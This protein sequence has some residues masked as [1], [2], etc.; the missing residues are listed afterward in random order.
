[1]SGDY[2]FTHDYTGFATTDNWRHI[3]VFKRRNWLPDKEIA[4]LNMIAYSGSDSNNVEIVYQQDRLKLLIDQTIE[5]DTLI[6]EGRSL[7]LGVDFFKA[8]RLNR[9]LDKH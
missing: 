8:R 5:L 1:M 6:E 4:D 2:Y 7:E 9:I 3:T